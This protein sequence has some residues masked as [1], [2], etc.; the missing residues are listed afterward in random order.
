MTRFFDPQKAKDPHKAD[1]RLYAPATAR[2]R[3][4]ILEVLKTYATPSGTLL[5]LAS[6]SGE[7]AAYMA[8]KL[9]D[10]TWQPSDIEDEKLASIDAWRTA[11]DT[12]NILPAA[13]LDVLKQD[14]SDLELPA[15]LTTV[16]SA[17]L[18]HIA[19]WQVAEALIEKAGKAL[20]TSGMLF[21]Y[22]PFKRGG[23]HT[24]PS[25]ESFD[26]S[27]KSRDESWGV[28]DLEEV[29]ALA[30][31]AGFTAPEII[32]MPANNLSVIFRRN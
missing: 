11:T 3:D 2:N 13:R 26:I 19:P 21:L 27:L 15:P 22:G 30:E 5:E 10:I 16:M 9:P 7:H 6:G 4:I 12:G 29:V 24:A 28:R 8:P 1:K 32:D 20:E 23:A 25:N 14:F 17:N 18:I 31:K